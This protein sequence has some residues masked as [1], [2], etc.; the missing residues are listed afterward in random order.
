M[1]G[2]ATTDGREATQGQSRSVFLPSEESEI[3]MGHATDALIQQE[4]VLLDDSELGQRVKAIGDRLLGSMERRKIDYRF[5][6]LNHND[7][8]ALSAPGGYIYITYGMLRLAESEEE[9]AAILA[10]EIAHVENRHHMQ[11]YR[12]VQTAQLLLNA[13]SIGLSLSVGG[14]TSSYIRQLGPLGVLIVINTFS[15]VQETEADDDALYLLRRA[16]YNPGGLWTILERIYKE[17]EKGKWSE[18]IPSIFLTHPPNPARIKR[19]RDRIQ[20][21]EPLSRVT[22]HEK[23][24]G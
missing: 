2:C 18:H 24:K 1:A 15:R 6:I 12:S 19:I 20:A 4:F 21:G 7:L 23:L 3:K 11:S 5:R 13:A 17:K 22:V 8:N 16:G 9:V 10:H 14:D